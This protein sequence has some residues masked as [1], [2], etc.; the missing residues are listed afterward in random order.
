GNSS[1]FTQSCGVLE[2]CGR[3][4]DFV[5]HG[6]EV[7]DARKRVTHAAIRRVASSISSSVWVGEKL[8]RSAERSTVSG[9]FIARSTGLG[10]RLPLEH[11]EP[12]EHATPSKSSAIRS[13]SARHPGND[14]LSVVGTTSAAPISGPL[15][16][17]G[18]QSFCKLAQNRARRASS[19]AR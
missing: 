18:E 15:S 6:A 10:K 1:V 11:A 2:G 14:T 16:T 5:L 9:T 4:A 17:T 19:F 8:N 12:V 13:R 3:N 7:S